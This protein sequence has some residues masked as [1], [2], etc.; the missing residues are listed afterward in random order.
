MARNQEKAQAM[1]NRFVQ[2]KKD[3]IKIDMGK[4]PILASEILAVREC[5]KWRAEIIR[6]VAKMVGQIQNGALGEHRIRELNDAIN[7]SLR[8][9]KHWER[10]IIFL[11]GADYIKQAPKI[12]DADGRIAMGADGYFYFGAARDLPGVR[13]LFEKKVPT[14]PKRTRGDLYKS[15]DADYYGYRDDDDG[16]LVKL[17]AEQEKKAV[18]AEI[19]DWRKQQRD[20]RRARLETLGMSADGEED[21]DIPINLNTDNILKA[22]VPLPSNTEI[23]SLVLAKRKREAL[24]RLQQMQ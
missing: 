17:E 10:Q 12:A 2:M 16:L 8:E 13:E 21:A 15:V 11:G 4:R 3:A 18:Q 14:E 7:K 5:E 22:H 23:E 24:E 6:E 9:K 19:D 1:M 20:L